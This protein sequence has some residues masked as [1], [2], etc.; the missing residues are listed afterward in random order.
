MKP[1]RL[2]L[3]KDG[4]IIYYSKEADAGFWDNLWEG[5]ISWEY[6]KEY[7][8]GI[9]GEYYPF[10]EKYLS[11][12]DH[13]LEAGCGTGR[14]VVAL[15]ARGYKFVNGIDWGK[16]TIDKV[17]SIFPDLPVAV[18]DATKVNVGNDYYDGYISLG[19][20]EH[21][22]AGPEPFLIE[23]YRIIKPGGYAFF[24][25]PY[26]NPLRNMKRI[27]GYYGPRD[28]TGL[29]FYQYAFNKLDFRNFL[30]EAGF[31]LVKI[32]GVSGIYGLKEELPL[33]AWLLNNTP[34][35]WRIEAFL[36]KIKWFDCFGHMILFIC[37]K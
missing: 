17:K 4:R 28:L 5:Q 27:L 25:V 30:E 11:R 15:K 14:Y 7:E 31:H 9:L 35:A 32:H 3:W 37:K 10:F 1:N 24:S 29:T 20:V 33:L 16:Q 26:V 19:V 21:R 12:E 23:A 8:S 18:G 2:K 34:G 13:I 22:E 36:K 6:Y